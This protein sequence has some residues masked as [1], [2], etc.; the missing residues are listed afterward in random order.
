[1]YQSLLCLL[2]TGTETCNEIANVQGCAN[3]CQHRTSWR[4]DIQS[5]RKNI[6]QRRRCLELLLAVHGR[7]IE[8]LVWNLAQLFGQFSMLSLSNAWFKINKILSVLSLGSLFLYLFKTIYKTVKW[9]D[10]LWVQHL[11]LTLTQFCALLKIVLF[12]RA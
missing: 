11:S 12:C 4:Y 9:Q 8:H 10:K 6:N 5:T 2:S 3:I 7:R 1:M